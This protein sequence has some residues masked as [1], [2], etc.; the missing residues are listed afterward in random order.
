MTD[1]RVSSEQNKVASGAIEVHGAHFMNGDWYYGSEDGKQIV[2]DPSNRRRILLIP[3]ATIQDVDMA[4]GNAREAQEAW[5]NL[6]PSDREMIM[7]R[8]VRLLDERKSD[9]AALESLDTGKPLRFALAEMEAAVSLLQFHAGIPKKLFGQQVPTDDSGLWCFT[10]L[11]PVGVVA[12][13]TPWN[14]PLLIGLSKIAAAIAAGCGIVIKPS[15]E[16][17]LTTLALSALAREAGCP[18]GLVNVITGGASAGEA[19]S[20]SNGFD[21][22]SFTGSTNTASALMRNLANSRRPI[23]L[24][25]G[26]KNPNLVFDDIEI[27][28]NL[29]G[30][31]MAAFQ[32]A[33]QECCAGA[34]ILVKANVYDEFIELA[35]RWIENVPVGAPIDES[36][37]IGPLISERH[38]QRVDGFVERAIEAGA[39][40]SARGTCPSDGF[41]YPPTMI[42]N[43]SGSMEICQEEVFGPV[44]T[45]DRFADDADALRMANNTPY[46]LAAGVWTGSI[47]RARRF[48]A[49]LKVGVVW[50]NSFLAEDVGAPFG[51]IRGSGFGREHGLLGCREF[52]QT[53]TVYIRGPQQ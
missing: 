30:I 47:E 19:L 20:A 12:A 25:L 46:G 36:S 26:G 18:K 51:G 34:R 37:V 16:T 52:C 38:R 41:Y 48:A 15:P 28:P 7:H 33:G 50:I 27:G 11:E 9:Y 10:I 53:K 1:I 3:E 35:G 32:N 23:V 45:V 49:E 8:M 2:S 5:W 17:P 42:T 21:K 13:I 39:T 4:I 29:N 14:Y 24:E 44:I 40:V 22:L 31:L 43:V 6:A